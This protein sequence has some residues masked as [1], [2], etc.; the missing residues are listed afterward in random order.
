[1][2]TKKKSRSS[3]TTKEKNKTRP[4]TLLARATRKISSTKRPPARCQSPVRDQPSAAL[5]I[6]VIREKIEGTP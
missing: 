1:M 4:V 5:R 6:A 2:A 3:R